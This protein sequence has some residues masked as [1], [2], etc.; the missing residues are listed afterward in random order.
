MT[1]LI[2]KICPV[3]WWVV[4]KIETS[5]FPEFSVKLPNFWA[6][7]GN[8]CCL[9]RA[10]YE[11]HKHSV[12][13]YTYECVNVKTDNTYARTTV[14]KGIRDFIFFYSFSVRYVCCH[15]IKELPMMLL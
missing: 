1:S 15:S 11:T 14:F 10:A 3:W 12:C 5:I 9:F 13:E 2:P 4:L 8:N 7:R 6:S